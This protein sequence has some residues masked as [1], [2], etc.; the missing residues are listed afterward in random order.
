MVHMFE[1]ANGADFP[2]PVPPKHKRSPLLTIGDTVWKQAT[3]EHATVLF[4]AARYFGILR[5][6]MRRARHSIFIVGWDIDSRTRLVG[7]SGAASD[8]APETLGDFLTHLVTARR[9]LDIYVLPW[10]YSLLFMRERELLPSVALGWKTPER[11]HVCV[12]GT[13]PT[14]ASHHQKL[15]VIDDSIAF[16]GGLDLTLRRWDTDD[17][18]IENARRMD[19]AGAAYGPYHDYQVMVDGDAARAL[20]E[21]AR[22]RW[23]DAS[24]MQPKPAPTAASPWPDAVNPD[25]T[26]VTIGISR[27]APERLAEPAIDEVEKLYYRSIA[28]ARRT[29]YVENQYLNCDALA[30][31]LV[32]QA[33]ANPD[34]EVILITNQ[35]A[36]GWLEE[37]TM[38]MGRRRFMAILAKSSAADRFRVLRSMVHDDNKSCEIHIHAKV[39]IV[40][41]R[42]LRVGSSNINQRSMGLDTECD[43]AI[44]AGTDEERNQITD[45]RD[46]MIAHHL[47]IERDA[48]RAL[49]AAHGS[50]I[51]AIEACDGNART[52]EP[53]DPNQPEAVINDDLEAS[54]AGMTDPKAPPH[55]AALAATRDMRDP[56]AEKSGIPIRVVAAVVVTAL[57][58]ILWYATP[59]ADLADV[60]TLEPYFQQIAD[61]GWAP[62]VVPLVIVLASMAFFP[63]TILIALTGMTLGPFLGGACA[64]A[65]CLGSAAISFGIGTLLGENGLRQLMGKRLNRI[66]KGMASKGVLAVAGLRLVPV[67]PFTAINLIAGATHIRLGDFIAGTAL[68]MAPGIIIM[69]ALGDRLR[70]IW[71]DPSPQNMVVLGLIVAGWL[72]IA[73][74]LQIVISR[75]RGE[76]AT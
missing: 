16:C 72:A 1:A 50:V 46:R 57:F 65:G 7:P 52:L 54:L 27:T 25:F 48:F 14:G 70:M 43:L 76:D 22:Q 8:G 68:G 4:D 51:A 28:A 41:D 32:A 53:I 38:G 30:E 40:D 44:E 3:A 67:A 73:V 31:S 59:I 69:S 47:G 66:S 2:E 49:L 19:P 13:A 63:V 58:L 35:D 62:V 24:G 42:L 15:V 23:A 34:L 75:R 33:E 18:A 36:G 61:S 56:D 64:G 5:D 39:M 11:V 26:A 17:H 71:Q 60:R 20:G 6:A 21:V 12:D 10:D 45:I 9:D 74:G 37:R 29:L 55:H